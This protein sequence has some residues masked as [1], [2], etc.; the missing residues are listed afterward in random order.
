MKYIVLA[1]A[2][3]MLMACGSNMVYDD[4][5][6]SK[7][8]IAAIKKINSLAGGLYKPKSKIQLDNVIYDNKPMALN[9]FIDIDINE[10]YIAAIPQ[11]GI[12]YLWDKAGKYITNIG[13]KGFSPGMYR[14]ALS[15]AF[16]GPDAIWVFDNMKKQMLKYKIE[17]RKA[18]LLETHDISTELPGVLVKFYG[19]AGDDF[20]FYSPKE[21]DCD[22][23]LMADEKMHFHMSFKHV[24]SDKAA[25]VNNL[26]V[27][28]KDRVYVSDDYY[29]RTF[30]KHIYDLRSGRIEVYDLK[31][32][33]LRIHKRPYK[34]PTS[35][36]PTFDKSGRIY[37]LLQNENTNATCTVYDVN[38]RKIHSYSFKS[39]SNYINENNY[40]QTHNEEVVQTHNIGNGHYRKVV[41]TKPADDTIS[42]VLYIWDFE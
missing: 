18:I 33:L 21:K 31:G 19:K 14:Y 9:Q 30:N 17:N 25:G 3:L 39:T 6:L 34:M 16:D 20:F 24:E 10:N 2:V 5:D 12:V 15:I 26:M 29:P 22:S 4:I 38:G 32:N 8:E 7:D 36:T 11:F 23:I 37:Y 35:L 1:L 13:S 42:A 27:V 28:N 40:F 41:V